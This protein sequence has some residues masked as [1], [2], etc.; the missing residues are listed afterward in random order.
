MQV[1]TVSCDQIFQASGYDLFMHPGGRPTKN[2]RSDMGARIAQARERAGLSQLDVAKKLGITQQ[3]IAA[4][5]RKANVVRSDTLIKLAQVLGVSVNEVL[6]VDQP[7]PKPFV[8]RGR[9]QQ[10]FEAASRLPRRQQHHILKVLEA[11]VGQH[12]N[13]AKQHS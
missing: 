11:F 4:L 9:L 1:K 7:K 8:A 2:P 5:E 3:S 6:G 13:G 12:S 10:V